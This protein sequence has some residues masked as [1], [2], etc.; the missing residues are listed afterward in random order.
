MDERLRRELERLGGVAFEDAVVF[1]SLPEQAKV[2]GLREHAGPFLIADSE[3]DALA[4]RWASGATVAESGT[5]TLGGR[6][7]A[8]HRLALPPRIRGLDT[9]ISEG[10]DAVRRR[11]DWFQRRRGPGSSD[12]SSES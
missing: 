7:C 6:T 2:V 11:E 1:E 3:V 4:E 8:L 5:L 9:K 10:R 12:S